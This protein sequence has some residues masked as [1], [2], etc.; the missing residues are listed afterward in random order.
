MTEGH[1]EGDADGGID[2]GG[3]NRAPGLDR[4]QLH[5]YVQTGEA[6]ADFLQRRFNLMA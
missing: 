6:Q 5:R 1:R 2:E 4:I 3:A